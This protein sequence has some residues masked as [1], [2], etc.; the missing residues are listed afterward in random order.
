[1]LLVQSFDVVEVMQ[2]PI[3]RGVVS[4]AIRFTAGHHCH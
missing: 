4:R 3:G 2:E 1:M